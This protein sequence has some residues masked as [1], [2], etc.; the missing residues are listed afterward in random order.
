MMT[1]NVSDDEFP[2]ALFSCGDYFLSLRDSFSQRLLDEDVTPSCKCRL[3]ERC[4]SVRVSR[5]RD[6]IRFSLFESFIVIA[7]DLVA[8][9]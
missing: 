8:S 3:G 1:K 5:D 7:T 9:S 6:G 2:T 4:V